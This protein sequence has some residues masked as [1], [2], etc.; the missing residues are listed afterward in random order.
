MNNQFIRRQTSAINIFLMVIF[1]LGLTSTSFVSSA[2]D[3]DSQNAISNSAETNLRIEADENIQAEDLGVKEAKILPTSR[4][5]FFKNAWRGVQK[6]VTLDPIKDAELDIKF[7]NEKLIEAKQVA[8]KT[9][10]P[11]AIKQALDNYHKEINSAKKQIDDLKTNA[12]SDK[13]MD[14]LLDKM[15]DSNIKQ[16]KLMDKI[17]KVAPNS[18]F[19]KLNEVKENAIDKFASS[20]TKIASPDVLKDRIENIMDKQKGSE[21]KNFKNLEVLK[22]IEDKMPEASKEAMRQAQNVVFQRFERDMQNGP[23]QIRTQFGDY[24]RNMGGDKGRQLEILHTLQAKEEMPEN[25]RNMMGQARSATIDSIGEKMRDFDKLGDFEAQKQ[26]DIML[27]RFENGDMKN[28]RIMKELENNLP[29]DIIEK[30]IEIK[31][32]TMASLIDNIREADTPEKQAIF[33]DKL[34]DFHDVRQFEMFKE[35]DN[36]IPEDKKDFWGL[37]EDKAKD[38]MQNEVSQAKNEAERQMIFAKM[39]GDDPSHIQMLKEFGPPAEIL[40]GIMQEQIMNLSKKIGSMEDAQRLEILK[41]KMQEEDDIRQEIERRNPDIFRKMEKQQKIVLA[42]NVSE[43]SVRTQI[44]KLEQQITESEQAVQNSDQLFIQNTPANFFLQASKERLANA[45]IALDSGK[46][47]E[48]FGLTTSGLQ[49]AIGAIRISKEIEVRKDVMQKNFQKEFQKPNDQNQPSFTDE[50]KQDLSDGM[51]PQLNTNNGLTPF[52]DFNYLSIG[53]PNDPNF[54]FDAFIKSKLQNQLQQENK[55]ISPKLEEKYR[56]E[57]QRIKNDSTKA[58]DYIQQGEKI[59]QQMMQ[60]YKE[61]MPPDFHPQDINDMPSQTYQPTDGSPYPAS[62]EPIYPRPDD[63]QQGFQPSPNFNPPTEFDK[64]TKEYEQN[65]FI[66]KPRS[67]Y[68]PMSNNEP[69]TNLQTPPN[70]FVAPPSSDYPSQ[71]PSGDYNP[72]PSDVNYSPP[73]SSSIIS[74]MYSSIIRP[75]LSSI[76]GFFLR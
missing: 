43:A 15:I 38:E 6:L 22:A 52:I 2:K 71:V 74:R 62:K 9:D 67:N 19:K 54:N 37:M 61:P 40:Q 3:T 50:Q 60:N 28:V 4:L 68:V 69:P 7:A 39:A 51:N 24:T 44:L 18:V 23:E 17:E 35:M 64:P 56:L 30:I 49:Q 21:F 16:Q 1:I 31:N 45:K 76:V 46:I 75:A 8:E 66:N 63:G 57:G 72:P 73:P 13:K 5:Y 59:R 12:G 70:T 55:N 53:Q 20:A 58:N 25:M 36:L 33:F 11:E 32:K 34:K 65:E 48:A 14:A 26:K 29:P 27:K 42:N 10:E 47:G 41:S